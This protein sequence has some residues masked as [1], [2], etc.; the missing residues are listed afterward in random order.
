MG[1]WWASVLC[2]ARR[3]CRIVSCCGGIGGEKMWQ[4]LFGTFRWMPVLG[5]VLG[6]VGGYFF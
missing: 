3:S 4:T 6:L 1:A 2:A 5:V